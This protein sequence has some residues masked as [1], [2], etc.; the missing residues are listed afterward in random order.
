[1]NF[2]LSQPWAVYLALLITMHIS[3]VTPELY[4]AVTEMEELLETEALLIDNLENYISVTSKKLEYLR[5]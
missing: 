1:M 3:V 4:T 2:K 5:M